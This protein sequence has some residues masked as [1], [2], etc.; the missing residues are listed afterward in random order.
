MSTQPNT[1]IPIIAMTANAMDGDDQKCYDAG[2]D[3]YIPKPIRPAGLIE[4][5][6]NATTLT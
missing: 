2:M 6:E 5:I 3:G 1:H 4:A